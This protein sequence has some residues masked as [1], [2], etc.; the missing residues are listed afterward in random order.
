MGL[1][2]HP[3][4]TAA[5][6]SWSFVTGV[7]RI[8]AAFG[9]VFWSAPL[10]PGPQGWRLG[11]SSSRPL[12]GECFCWLLHININC[13][14]AIIVAYL[15]HLFIA[16]L[17]IDFAKCQGP[18]HYLTSFLQSM[19]LSLRFLPSYIFGKCPCHLVNW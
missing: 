4:T 17:H 9:R 2:R 10:P 18:L 6:D 7:Q 3:L 16:M 11:H 19:T 13:K 15:F 8:G 1:Y 12:M 14:N 5:Y